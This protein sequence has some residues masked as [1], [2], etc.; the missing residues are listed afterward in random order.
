MPEVN[1]VA[2]DNGQFLDYIF[3]LSDGASFDAVRLL[4]GGWV[5]VLFG[6]SSSGSPTILTN[7]LSYMNLISI[8]FCF[9]VCAYVVLASVV[10]TAAEGEV[11]GK[12]WSQ[13]WII[14][15]MVSALGLM[16]PLP[17]G[18]I[19]VNVSLIQVIVLWIAMV[20][21]NGADFMWQYAVANMIKNEASLNS[22]SMGTKITLDMVRIMYC[23]SGTAK[24]KTIRGSGEYEYG[25]EVYTTDKSGRRTPVSG[26]MKNLSSIDP[27]STV[28]VSFGS[29]TNSCGYIS[30]EDKG[31]SN[32]NEIVMKHM[33]N[34]MSYIYKEI[35]TPLDNEKYSVGTI[36]AYLQEGEVN[37]DRIITDSLKKIDDMVNKYNEAVN[38]DFENMIKSGINSDQMS[39]AMEDAKYAKNMASWLF[40]GSFYNFFDEKVVAHSNGIN[41]ANNAVN[42]I[43][44][45]TCAAEMAMVQG[46]F[47]FAR[48]FSSSADDN[49]CYSDLEKTKGNELITAYTSTKNAGR[50][51]GD[52]IGDNDISA[53]CSSATSC[54]PKIVMGDFAKALIPTVNAGTAGVP[55]GFMDAIATAGSWAIFNH[56]API[57]NSP[58]SSVIG[59]S[60]SDDNGALK[61]GNAL[62]TISAMGHSMIGTVKNG[63][64]LYG[65]M[66]FLHGMT[67]SGPL[68][69]FTGGVSKVIKALANM[70]VAVIILVLPFAVQCAYFIPLIPAIIWVAVAIGW[71][72]LL[73]EAFAAS[74]LAVVQMAT[75]EGEGITG[76]RMEKAIALIASLVL[77]PSLSIVGLV[78]SMFLVNIGFTLFNAMLQ[79]ASLSVMGVADVVGIVSLIVIWSTSVITMVKTVF[80]IIP[81]LGNDILE[82]F[83]GGMSRSFGNNIAGEASTGFTRTSMHDMQTALKAS[84]GDKEGSVLGRAGLR[85]KAGANWA[86]G[87]WMNRKKG[88]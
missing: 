8:A 20:G 74:P 68:S 11:L 87:K 25:M 66:E 52:D 86:K 31:S 28:K 80:N 13:S 88:V 61:M 29:L 15:R 83:S 38:K 4:F 9:I 14:I 5:N 18:V 79:V 41:V 59:F 21:S 35:Y 32:V 73:V 22:N 50:T 17:A 44:P 40:A 82:W 56:G 76:H 70:L 39:G 85:T 84:G 60:Y 6:G 36:K 47:G 81:T 58:D 65:V 51:P 3:K 34:T 26:G 67:D 16:M 53:S 33:L 64:I 30:V 72:A 45:N 43:D 46:T 77:R 57:A 69:T 62:S 19:G 24:A 42:F 2:G 1:Q 71:L 7:V 23:A 49:T 55:V 63:L 10:K 48:L 27:K 75:P 78:A 12:S 54:D 37:Q